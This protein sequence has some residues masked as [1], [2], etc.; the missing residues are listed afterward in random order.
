MALWRVFKKLKDILC[1]AL[2]N[3]L[4]YA[5]A[6]GKRVRLR[7]ELNWEVQLRLITTCSRRRAAARDGDEP[8]LGTGFRPNCRVCPPVS[9][10]KHAK[11]WSRGPLR[12]FAQSRRR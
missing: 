5:T 2:Y 6:I 10:Q 1:Y 12:W 4:S 11:E 7:T 3:A 8:H 9:M